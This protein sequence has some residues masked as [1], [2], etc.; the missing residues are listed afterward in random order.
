MISSCHMGLIDNNR[1]QYRMWKPKQ[2]SML[3]ALTKFLTFFKSRKI[4]TFSHLK[5]INDN[6][7]VKCGKD[8][9]SC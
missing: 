5:S 7:K 9:I 6:F 8:K 1:N 3:V 4:V 2:F